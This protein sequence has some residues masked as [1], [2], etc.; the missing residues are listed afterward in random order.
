MFWSS[1]KSVLKG[2]TRSS[3][4]RCRGRPRLRA[5]WHFRPRP[6]CGASSRHEYPVPSAPERRARLPGSPGRSDGRVGHVGRSDPSARSD[7][8]CRW[9][10]RKVTSGVTTWNDACSSWWVNSVP[11]ATARFASSAHSTA[12]VAKASSVTQRCMSLSN[13]SRRRTQPPALASSA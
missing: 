4:P 1:A 10:G 2:K 8:A 11:S 5:L 7:V 6:G 12:L 3:L 13:P 9:L